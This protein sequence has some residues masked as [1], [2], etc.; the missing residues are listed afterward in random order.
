MGKE[1]WE[2]YAWALREI[3]MEHGNLSASDVPYKVKTVFEKYMNM[4]KNAIHPDD[5]NE[6]TAPPEVLKSQKSLRF[7]KESSN[8]QRS[9]SMVEKSSGDNISTI[10][11]G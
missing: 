10:N 3:I 4:A 1:R 7:M 2:V 6:E 8:F 9:Y 11:G 5:L